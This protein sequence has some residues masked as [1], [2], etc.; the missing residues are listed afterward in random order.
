MRSYIGTEFL[1]YFIL[2]SSEYKDKS[3]IAKQTKMKDEAVDKWL[4]YLFINRSDQS[5]YSSLIKK[6]QLQYALGMDEYPKTLTEAI[7]ALSNHS[8]DPQFYE[9]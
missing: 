4:A 8:F 9:N 7:N 2:Q 1:E 5:K 6:L 3:D